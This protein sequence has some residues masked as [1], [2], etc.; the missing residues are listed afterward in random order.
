MC[1]Y[2]N[3]F[4]KT[5]T[6]GA[7]H[8]SITGAILSLLHKQTPATL[9]RSRR[10][11]KAPIQQ[12]NLAFPWR[13]VHSQRRRVRIPLLLCSMRKRG[14]NHLFCVR[15]T[16]EILDKNTL[17]NRTCNESYLIANTNENKKVAR[18]AVFQIHLLLSSFRLR[19]HTL[20]TTLIDQDNSIYH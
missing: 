14:K 13:P 15:V 11:P 5:N 19:Y 17:A 2:T 20:D 3:L 10:T 12:T 4:H 7:A 9:S 16:P 8:V 6:T 1:F 18:E